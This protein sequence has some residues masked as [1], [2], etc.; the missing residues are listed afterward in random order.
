MLLIANV[1]IIS[2]WTTSTLRYTTLPYTNKH[3]PAYIPKYT[4]THTHL[5]HADDVDAAVELGILG[6]LDDVKLN[7]G[8][9]VLRNALRRWALNYSALFMSNAPLPGL[10]DFGDQAPRFSETLSPAGVCSQ[11]LENVLFAPMCKLILCCVVLCNVF[12]FEL[13]ECCPAA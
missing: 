5:S 11:L 9:M 12:P 1:C 13:C 4:S 7:L 10:E 2:A 6:Q 8:A 3:T